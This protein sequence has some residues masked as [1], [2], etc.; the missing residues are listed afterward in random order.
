MSMSSREELTAILART[1]GS[2]APAPAKVA[3]AASILAMRETV[4]RVQAADHVSDYIARLVLATHPGAGASPVAARYVRYGASP[5]AAQAIMLGAK[6]LALR[7]GRANISFADVRAVAPAALR[8]RL[9][10]TF[11]GQAEGIAPSTIVTDVLENVPENP[12]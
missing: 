9:V 10:L 11:E 7:D 4:R 1:T 3:D 5:R 8:H 6:V 2:Q 12:K